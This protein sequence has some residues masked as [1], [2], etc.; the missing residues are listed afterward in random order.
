M[1]LLGRKKGKFLRGG[2][3]DKE[4][5]T[6]QGPTNSMRVVTEDWAVEKRFV[7][8]CS[9]EKIREAEEFDE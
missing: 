1:V 6:S 7:E 8:L 4:A 3:H 9:E 2:R 5:Y